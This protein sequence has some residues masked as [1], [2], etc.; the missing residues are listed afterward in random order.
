MAMLYS[1]SSPLQKRA[2]STQ[3]FYMYP[4]TPCSRATT[5]LCFCRHGKEMSTLFFFNCDR[6]IHHS[7]DRLVH[8]QTTL[9]L[10]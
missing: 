5:T 6:L 4:H 10:S 8:P 2:D 9:M 7:S 1:Y 3:K